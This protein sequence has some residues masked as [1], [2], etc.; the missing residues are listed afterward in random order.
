MLGSRHS[1][2]A[3]RSAGLATYA[4]VA[5]HATLRNKTPSFDACLTSSLL[6]STLDSKWSSSEPSYST[7]ASPN[8]RYVTQASVVASPVL[9][10]EAPF[11]LIRTGGLSLDST[12]GRLGLHAGIGTNTGGELDD[13]AGER[14]RYL[15]LR[16]SLLTAEHRI[17]SCAFLQVRRN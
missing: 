12:L 14:T 8:F 2:A 16:N 13:G 6:T 11:S 7:P 3:L 17:V 15:R 5:L 4:T 9:V 10:N 1:A